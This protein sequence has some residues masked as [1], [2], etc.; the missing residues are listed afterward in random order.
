MTGRVGFWV[1]EGPAVIHHNGKIYLTYSASETGAAYCVG[2]MSASED[3]DLLD[4]KSWTKERYPVLCTDADRGVY[5]PGHNSFTEDEEGN[6]IMVYHARI[7][8]KIEGNPLY[9]PNR[10]AM[11]MKI[12]WDEKTGAPV[13]SYEN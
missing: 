3:S 13:F 8:E 6:P 12:H 9:N 5:G 1:N 10:H 7:E 4:P 2:M 11:L